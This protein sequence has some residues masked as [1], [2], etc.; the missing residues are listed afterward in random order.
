MGKTRN[1]DK[2]GKG[3]KLQAKNQMLKE[4]NAEFARFQF[5][6]AA[7]MKI[8]FFWDVKYVKAT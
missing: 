3:R 2:R 5:L 4:K 1:V 8:E 6:T 7:L